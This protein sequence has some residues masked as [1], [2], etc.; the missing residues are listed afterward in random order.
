VRYPRAGSLHAAA[1]RL[2]QPQEDQV[3]LTLP[4]AFLEDL[5][6]TLNELADD[7]E[8]AGYPARATSARR[9]AERLRKAIVKVI[10]KAIPT[11][12]KQ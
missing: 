5:V 7:V 11:K 9:K 4:A 1:N 6:D 8:D 2:A 10:V 12:E 3:K